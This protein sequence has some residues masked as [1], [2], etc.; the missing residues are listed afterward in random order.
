MGACPCRTRVES[1]C[2]NS[3]VLVATLPMTCYDIVAS[4]TLRFELQTS[5]QTAVRCRSGVEAFTSCRANKRSVAA[6][7]LL[8]FRRHGTGQWSETNAGL[9]CPHCVSCSDALL[10]ERHCRSR[11]MTDARAWYGRRVPCGRVR[12]CSTCPCH[13]VFHACTWC[14]HRIRKR[15]LQVCL[16]RA[17]GTPSPSVASQRDPTVAVQCSRRNA[18]RACRLG[19]KL[20]PQLAPG[21]GTRS[22]LAAL[23]P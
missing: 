13:A 1:A 4:C 12:V 23:W 3:A 19:N 10:G 6:N 17:T 16:S 14:L 9:T 8:S 18:R 2:D 15:S 21:L 22:H 11:A 5:A 7:P 20:Q